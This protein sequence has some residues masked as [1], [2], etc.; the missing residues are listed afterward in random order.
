M[1][2]AICQIVALYLT[3]QSPISSPAQ[4]LSTQ[5]QTFSSSVW[6]HFSLNV[7]WRCHHVGK[8]IKKAKTKPV[9]LALME[10]HLCST[11]QITSM[12]NYSGSQAHLH[13]LRQFEWG[14][15]IWTSRCALASRCK[16]SATASAT[17]VRSLVSFAKEPARLWI[18]HWIH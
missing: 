18:K 16:D 12:Q 1:K 11:A 17:L 10:T 8:E 7:A 2:L 14:W 6:R 5:S 15:C 3:P 9:R 4:C 13:V